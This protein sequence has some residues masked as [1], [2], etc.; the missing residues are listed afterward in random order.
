MGIHRE[1][2]TALNKR[3][4]DLVSK[5]EEYRRLTDV[6]ET[7]QIALEQLRTSYSGLR[8]K[9][10]EPPH[11]PLNLSTPVSIPASSPPHAPD[12]G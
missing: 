1:E 12:P 7:L 8:G 10:I 9:S 5:V 4:D 11:V 2:V 6:V 3:I